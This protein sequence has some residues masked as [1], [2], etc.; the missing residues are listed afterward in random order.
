MM[1][2][3]DL[4]VHSNKSDG[5][6]TPKELV[7]YALEKGLAAFALTDHDSVSG[8]QEAVN[9]AK[10]SSLEVIPGIELSTEYNGRDIHILGYYIDIAD[11]SFQNQLSQFIDSRDIRNQK[12]CRLLHD[13][14][15]MDISFIQLKERFPK[16]TIT[17]AHYA[18]YMLDH[19]YVKSLAEAFD[20]YIGDHAP[21]Y[22]PREKVS[23]ADGIKLILQA[24]GV[25]VLAHPILYGLGKSALE[26]LISQLKENGLMGIEAIYTTY[27]MSDT[28]QIKSL[29]QKYNLFITGGSDFHGVNKVNTDLG[30]GRGNL[31]V[32]YELL[33]PIKQ[34][35]KESHDK[36]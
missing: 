34:A 18:K 17:R 23:P 3:I 1:E 28:S 14:T 7:D 4:H 20:R 31:F 9:A 22:L 27:T 10:G 5:S 32:P 19:G 36:H 33:L 6:L 13:N 12:M 21:F 35:A 8:I 11:S 24:D 30:T 2:R 26:T 15:N 29:A 16:A 25:P